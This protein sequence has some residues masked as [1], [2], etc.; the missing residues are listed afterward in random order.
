MADAKAALE[1]AR[2]ILMERFAEDA[3]LVGRLRE[4]LQ[5]RGVVVSKVADG[6][7][8]A[9]AKFADYFDY[10]EALK[11]I[12]SHRALA[13][14]RGRREE[15]LAVSLRMP[16]DLEAADGAAVASASARERQGRRRQGPA[17]AA[18]LL[19]ADDRRACR[20]QG[21][22]AAPPMPGCARPRAGPGR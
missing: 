1:G 14:L 12:P 18:R 5:S 4:V 3:A 9:G 21:P 19:R 11:D 8:E 13:L 7:Q 22:R 2:H 17:G 15:V 6:K 16:E 10:Q 20:H